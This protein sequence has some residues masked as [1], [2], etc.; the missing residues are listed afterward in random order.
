VI[1]NDSLGEKKILEIGGGYSFGLGNIRYLRKLTDTVDADGVIKHHAFGIDL[2]NA[3]AIVSKVF[4]EAKKESLS[5]KE[6]EEAQMNLAAIKSG[7][8]KGYDWADIGQFQDDNGNPLTFDC[9]FNHSIG[10]TPG[11][12]E[13]VT[14]AALNPGGYYIAFREQESES[15]EPVDKIFFRDKKKYEDYSFSFSFKPN[16]TSVKKRYDVTIFQKLLK[17]HHIQEDTRDSTNLVL[18]R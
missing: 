17:I 14:D 2:R 7:A 18:A 12:Y 5:K 8:I 6:L 10:P 11:G 9:I 16:I 3:E 13:K 15:N 1:D 4:T